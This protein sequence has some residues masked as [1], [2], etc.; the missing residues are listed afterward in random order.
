MPA[1][2]EEVEEAITRKL[3]SDM[4]DLHSSV[5]GKVLQ[6]EVESIDISATLVKELLDQGRS[7]ESMLPATVLD[8]IEE[9]HL[10]A[11]T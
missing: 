11:K 8:Y 2:R 4:S 1:I 3:T 7:P 10:Y 5:A 9:Q 6:L